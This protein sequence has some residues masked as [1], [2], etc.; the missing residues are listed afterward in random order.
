[1]IIKEN[2]QSKI[3]YY[4]C[5]APILSILYFRIVK[6][7]IDTI[8]DFEKVKIGRGKSKDITFYE[9]EMIK[10]N[11]RSRILSDENVKDQQPDGCDRTTN[12]SLEL[13]AAKFGDMPE[14]YVKYFLK[15]QFWKDDF[16][17]QF[18]F[19]TFY[20]NGLLLFAQVRNYTLFLNIQHLV[21]IYIYR[22]TRSIIIYWS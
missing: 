8:S 12:N 18:S 4:A 11:L 22:V 15:E 2:Q 21:Y 10:D 1:M 3:G 13:N 17:I 14:S 7:N 6:F 20:K 19:R 5:N 16:S 9:N